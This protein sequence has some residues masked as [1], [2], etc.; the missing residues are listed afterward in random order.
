MLDSFRCTERIAYTYWGIDL[1]TFQNNWAVN[2]LWPSYLCRQLIKVIKKRPMTP[3]Y[4]NQQFG[5]S[6][7]IV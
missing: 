1:Y 4:T 3:V 5:S 2:F 6:D 7:I